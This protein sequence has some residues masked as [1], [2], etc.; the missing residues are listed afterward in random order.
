MQTASSFRDP[1]GFVFHADGMIYRQVNWHY[2]A[3]Y[4]HLMQSG[5]YERLIQA[6]LL[7]PHQEVETVTDGYRVIKPEQLQI[8]SY[9]YEWSFSQLKAAALAT[10][11][12][13][14]IALSYQMTLKDSSAY[15]I[16]FV[17]GKPLL[18]DTL[19]FEAYQPGMVWV[20]YRQFCQH[21]LAPLAM[22]SYT[23]VRL[24]QL[25][26]IY[27]DGIPLDLAKKLLPPRA[28]LQLSLL[29]HIN[30]HALGQKRFRGK[31]IKKPV[32]KNSRQAL[33][34]L[35]DNL[36]HGI[37]KLTWNSTDT[38]WVNYY[39]DEHSY[40]GESFEHKKHLVEQ[41]IERVKPVSV[42]DLGANTGAFSR[43]A[44]HRRI[45]TVA[46]DIDPA[47]VE[48]N[49]QHINQQK[50]NN[51]L[52]LVLDLTNPSP[53]LGWAHQERLSLIQRAPVEMVF[54][55]ALIHHLVISNNVPLS[56]T[57]EFFSRLCQWLV[58]EFVPRHDPKVQVLLT[59]RQDIFTDYTQ[60]GFEV[61][62]TSYFS[63]EEKAHIQDSQ[64]VIYLMK[65]R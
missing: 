35:I 27:I 48:C 62:F 37:Q 43:L 46:W 32:Q 56:L 20:P 21:F 51:L 22:M 25:L 17:H 40:H 50:E 61:A 16:Q 1:S 2:Q 10:L 8:V 15:N 24:S 9:P 45:P 5:L 31:T 52:P 53:A 63:I 4:D 57:A 60:T 65:K 33:L 12:I 26:R 39:D 30:L 36:E 3:N 28:W 59:T 49:Y 19:S 55:L 58:I 11:A 41:F 13:Q 7:I 47:A 42:W 38:E 6:G 23:D 54:A 14:K 34:G 18:I 29:L 64:R 44:S